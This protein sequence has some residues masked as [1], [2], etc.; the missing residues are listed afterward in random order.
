MLVERIIC[1]MN[2]CLKLETFRCTCCTT[3]FEI[4]SFPVHEQ[5]YFSFWQ[6]LSK[7]VTVHVYN[8]SKQIRI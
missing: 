3:E 2:N 8:F 6:I 5:T 1:R 4:I 7:V